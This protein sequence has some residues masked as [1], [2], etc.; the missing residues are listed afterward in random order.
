[1]GNQ[2]RVSKRSIVTT[3]VG[4]RRSKQPMVGGGGSATPP[5]GPSTCPTTPPHIPHHMPH[6]RTACMLTLPRTCTH[7]PTPCRPPRSSCGAH[8]RWGRVK[9]S[10]IVDS[11]MG[12]GVVARPDSVHNT[13]HTTQPIDYIPR[14]NTDPDISSPP[15]SY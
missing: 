1:M 10:R 4:M 2:G 5:H 14:T 12:S 11:G 15:I 7:P 13:G 9:G 3:L 8:G 6:I